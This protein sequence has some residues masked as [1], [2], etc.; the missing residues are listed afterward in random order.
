MATRLTHVVTYRHCPTVGD[1]SGEMQLTNHML[2]VR[3]NVLIRWS[4]LSP[5]EVQRSIKLAKY[6]A[7]RYGK[8]HFF[9]VISPTCSLPDAESRKTLSDNMSKMTEYCA[10]MSVVI[11]GR[12]LKVATLRSVSASFLLFADKNM[13]VWSSLSEAV[14]TLRVKEAEDI[15][16]QATAAGIA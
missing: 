9:A 4:A 11:E 14:A 12:G 5:A 7:A 10:S 15:L 13:H 6:T 16:A 8:V 1:V 3:E 2:A